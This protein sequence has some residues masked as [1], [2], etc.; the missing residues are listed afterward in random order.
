MLEI[1]QRRATR[2][3]RLATPHIRFADATSTELDDRWARF[4]RFV[5]L[6]N[7]RG[8][9]YCARPGS[10]PTPRRAFA[11]ASRSMDRGPFAGSSRSRR[12]GRPG[13]TAPRS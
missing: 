8:T 3:T 5:I 12:S 10:R 9:Y 4:D 13:R 7:E 6:G 11:S 2:L 1:T